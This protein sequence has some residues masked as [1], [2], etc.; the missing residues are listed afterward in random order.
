[1]EDGAL[2]GDV[3]S[4]DIQNVISGLA[5]VDNHGKVVAA[6]D[7]Q[8]LQKKL[9][10]NILVLAVLPV[11]QTGLSN[12]HDAVEGQELLELGFPALDVVAAFGRRHTYRM[13]DVL[14]ALEIV[15]DLFEVNQT[16]AD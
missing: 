4:E 12:C 3:V 16:V 1:M 9:D 14:C 5:V 15:V 13:E 7:L 6:G 10:L 2:F 8:M 11:V